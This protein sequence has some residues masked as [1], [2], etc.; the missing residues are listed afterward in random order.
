VWRKLQQSIIATEL[1]TEGGFGG[2]LSGSEHFSGSREGNEPRLV[3]LVRWAVENPEKIAA[4]GLGLAAFGLA[5][6][7]LGN[8]K[9]DRLARPVTNEPDQLQPS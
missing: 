4:L 9:E 2:K 5:A 8:Y 7:F 3:Q 6:F 1:E